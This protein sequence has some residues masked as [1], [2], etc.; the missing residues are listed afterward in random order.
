MCFN[1]LKIGLSNLSEDLHVCRLLFHMFPQ[2]NSQ[3]AKDRDILTLN[4]VI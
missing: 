2:T 4:L 3:V 1:L